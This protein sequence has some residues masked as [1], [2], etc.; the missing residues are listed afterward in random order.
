MILGEG[1]LGFRVTGQSP[2]GM[3][4]VQSGGYINFTLTLSLQN[5]D[6]LIGDLLPDPIKPAI[7]ELKF[8]F[9][10]KRC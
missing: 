10:R 5:V 6:E 3:G 7:I 8:Y 4:W 9:K 1:R 2:D